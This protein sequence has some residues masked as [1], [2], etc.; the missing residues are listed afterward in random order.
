MARRA[1]VRLA[2]AAGLL[3]LLAHAGGETVLLGLGDSLARAFLPPEAAATAHVAFLALVFIASL[4]GLAVLLGG[5]FYHQGWMGLG[6]LFVALGAG[7]GLLGLLVLVGLSLASGRGLALLG[8]LLGPAGLGVV[9][10]I[11]ARR[12]VAR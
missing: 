1:A 7:T 6:N 11:L 12:E 2:V 4:G 5:V 8:W 3:L 9:L 10:S